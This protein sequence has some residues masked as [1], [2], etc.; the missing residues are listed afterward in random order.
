MNKAIAGAQE[1]VI[2]PAAPFATNDDVLATA[3]RM[4]RA[5]EYLGNMEADFSADQGLLEAMRVEAHERT[6]HW[7]R[8]LT[9]TPPEQIFAG[10]CRKHRFNR[11]ERE[12]LAALVLEKLALVKRSVSEFSEILDFLCLP[13]HRVMAALRVMSDEGRLFRAGLIEYEDPD[14]D[15]CSRKIVVDPAFVEEMLLGKGGRTAGWPVKTE[16]ELFDYLNSLIR[17]MSKQNQ[18]VSFMLRGH[19]SQAD[20]FKGA[21]LLDRQLRDFR[22]TVDLYPSWAIAQVAG[23]YDVNFY[24]QRAML[25]ILLALLGKEL[26]H[27]DADEELFQGGG[28]VRAASRKCEEV[29]SLFRLLEGNGP[30]VSDGLIQPCGGSGSHVEEG[31]NGLQEVEFE[32]TEATI[33]ALGLE[34]QGIKRRKSDS[35]VRQPLVTMDQLVLGPEVRRA[36]GMALTH[37]A[38]A[39][40]LVEDWGL[41]KAIPYGRSV[42][43]LFSGPP[44]VGKT[45][46]AEA[47]A[48][49]LER[50]IL[51]VDYSQVQNCF[52]GVTEKNIV[53]LFREATAHQAVLFWDE[54]DAMFYNRDS[55]CVTSM[56]CSRNWSVSRASVCW[57]PTAR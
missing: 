49:E 27:L 45:A 35:M 51:A 25:I 2:G 11:L 42:T 44:G 32:L 18:E 31:P 21:R 20:A 37:A 55:R 30:L 53:R 57:P 15:I 43:L 50:P 39:R 48:S 24:P 56:C 1:S 17:L 46:C 40:T 41:G 19:G 13:D 28:L 5:R 22:C 7:H 33:E 54:A 9:L 52:V 23:S 8:S 14:E 3:R 12:I 47:M 36:L 16:S 38:R 6:L 4:F 29:R 26:G 10:R 34:K